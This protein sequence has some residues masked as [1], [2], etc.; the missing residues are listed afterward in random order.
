MVKVRGVGWGRSAPLKVNLPGALKTV[1]SEI[2]GIGWGR[3]APLRSRLSMN[4]ALGANAVAR[5]ETTFI[6]LRGPRRAIGAPS[7]SRLGMGRFGMGGSGWGRLV[8]CAIAG[9]QGAA[10]RKAYEVQ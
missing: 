1:G 5:G 9:V 3:C 7:R 4:V 2:G 6:V 8:A 10:R